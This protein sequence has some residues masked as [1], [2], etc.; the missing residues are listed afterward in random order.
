MHL[1]SFHFDRL[2]SGNRQRLR[3]TASKWRMA[4]L[5]F[6]GNLNEYILDAS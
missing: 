1:R 2:R 6:E 4:H 5:K 3:L